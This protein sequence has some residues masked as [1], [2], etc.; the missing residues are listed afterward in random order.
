MIMI[1][2][3]FFTKPQRQMPFQASLFP[4][5]IPLHLLPWFYEELHFHL[6]KLPHTENEL[7]CY[8]LVAESL[9]RLSYLKRDFHSS[10]FLNIQKVY[11]KTLSRVWTYIQ[12]HRILSRS[13][14]FGSAH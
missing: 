7:T 10:C 12:L 6:F 13:S 8:Y 1:T 9:P 5:L 4:I 2:I 3:I 14:Q 11:A